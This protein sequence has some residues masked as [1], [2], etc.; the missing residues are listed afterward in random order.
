MPDAGYVPEIVVW[1]HRPRLALVQQ[2][3]DRLQGR[4]KLIAIGGP[5]EAGINRFAEARSIPH[6]DDPRR[7]IVEHPAAFTFAADIEQ[8][9]QPVILSA[10]SQG[11]TLLT[12]EPVAADLRQLRGFSDKAVKFSRIIDIPALTAMPGWAGAAD[13]L[14][15]IGPV[16]SLTWLAF[17]HAHECSLFSRLYEAWRFVVEQC[18]MPESINASLVATPS[19]S[20]A[21]FRAITG[22]LTAHGRWSD[23]AGI[24]MQLSDSASAQPN[25]SAARKLEAPSP[26]GCDRF[27]H[28]TGQAGRLRVTDHDYELFDQTGK[29]IDRSAPGALPPGFA[30]LII[31]ALDNLLRRPP[32]EDPRARHHAAAALACCQAALLSARTGQPESPEQQLHLGGW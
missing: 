26:G 3:I 19:E 1:T 7:L 21:D 27:L 18:H 10:L 11:T 20:Q 17:F 15:V 5:P 13:P 32:R 6:Y 4:V 14:G 29:L 9:P 16:E 30:E 2:V 22:S 25:P 8:F 24:V 23:A 12:I 31:T 28:I